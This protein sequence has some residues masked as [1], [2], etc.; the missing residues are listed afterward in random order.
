MQKMTVEQAQK[1]LM[2]IVNKID[3]NGERVI[4]QRNGRNCAVIISFTDYEA[5]ERIEN[6]VD[7]QEA[8]SALLEAEREGIIDFNDYV[9]EHEF[10]NE[11]YGDE[12]VDEEEYHDSGYHEEE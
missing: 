9:G 2:N 5:V 10:E 3:R 4:I 11:E 1:N 12:Y 8:D 6:I 7:L